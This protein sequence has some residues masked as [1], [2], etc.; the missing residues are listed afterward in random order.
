MIICPTTDLLTL[1]MVAEEARVVKSTVEQWVY[2]LELGSFKKGK[3]RRVPREDWIQFVLLHKFNPRR[4]DWHTA[5]VEGHLV[6]MLR[7]IIRQE[8]AGSKMERAA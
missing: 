2:D 6:E 1:D 7:G 4:P 8:I 3:I 5:Q